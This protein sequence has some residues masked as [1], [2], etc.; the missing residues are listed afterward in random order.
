MKL[1]I[2]SLPSKSGGFDGSAFCKKQIWQLSL[3]M[4]VDKQAVWQVAEGWID[5]ALVP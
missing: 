3:R 5:P 1:K 4:Q 2:I